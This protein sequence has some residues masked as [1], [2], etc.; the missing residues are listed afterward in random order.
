MLTGRRNNRLRCKQFVVENNFVK[1]VRDDLN[2]F[3]FLLSRESN[4]WRFKNAVID[5]MGRMF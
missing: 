3:F 2:V 5:L 4:G 1:V